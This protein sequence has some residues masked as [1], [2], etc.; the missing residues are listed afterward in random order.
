MESQQVSIF[1]VAAHILARKGEIGAMKLHKLL[2]YCQAWSLVW[3][4]RPLFTERIEAWVNGPVV[5][6]LYAAHRR[7]FSV[8]PVLIAQCQG[9]AERLN[10]TQRETVDAVLKFYGDRDA[11]WLSDLTH[12]E[13]P[14]QKARAGVERHERCENEITLVSMAEY[15]SSLARTQTG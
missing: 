15:Y 7:A 2:Y 9:R 8:P 11:Q 4:D 5:R 6:R 10:Q 14:W 3:D 12:S 1:D 13:A